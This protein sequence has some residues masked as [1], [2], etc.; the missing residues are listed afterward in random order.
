[1]NI[2]VLYGGSSS[3]REV[4]LS[5][6]KAIAKALAEAGHSVAAYDV[7]WYSKTSLFEAVEKIRKDVVDVV[8]L[9]LHGGLGENGGVQA[10]LEAAELPYTGSGVMASAVAMDK[11]YTKSLFVQYGIPTAP[12]LAGGGEDITPDAVSEHIGFPCVVKPADQG[13]T[14]G[15]SKVEQSTDIPAAVDYGLEASG[16]LIVEPYLAGSEL[17]VPVFNGA[18]Y[19]VIQIVPSH[20]IYDYECKYTKGRTDYYVPAPISEELARQVTYYALKAYKVLNLRDIS[21]ID[22]RLDLEGNPFC[23]EANTLP[24]MTDTSL[25]PKSA[26]Q[27]GI[28]FPEL[29]SNIAKSAYE[30][31]GKNK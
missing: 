31:K 5:S 13:S 12:W 26:A 19:P 4:S 16:K 14:V 25:V 24:G 8:Y 17:T 22:F 20:E 23:F 10:I 7:E 11:D 29:V 18:A 6:G 3:E 28:D 9:G 2:A 21:R 1:L 15:L 30:R 27:A